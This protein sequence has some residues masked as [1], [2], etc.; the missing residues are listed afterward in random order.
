MAETVL[1]PEFDRLLLLTCEAN[2][3]G[4]RLY[5][6]TEIVEAVYNDSE[7][8]KLIEKSIRE[9]LM[10]KILEKWTPVIKVH[11]LPS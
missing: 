9:A 10:I 1:P 2:V 7:A 8:R 4:E 6:Q 11:G 3:G 5:M